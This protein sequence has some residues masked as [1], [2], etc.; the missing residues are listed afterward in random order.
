MVFGSISFADCIVKC[1]TV[2]KRTKVVPESLNPTWNAELKFVGSKCEPIINKTVVRIALYDEDRL[3][4]DDFLGEI[5]VPVGFL[6]AEDA[7]PHWRPV[8]TRPGSDDFVS[9]E[10][11]LSIV[12]QGDENAGAGDSTGGAKK[13]KT[14]AG[15]ASKAAKDAPAIDLQPQ[16]IIDPS[17]LDFTNGKTLGE[18]SFGSV[19]LGEFRGL[20]VA[21]KT[22]I[23]RAD[24][25]KAEVVSDFKLEVE[26]MSKVSH[27]PKLC[28]FL[29]ASV[30]EPL[31]VVTELMSGG[32]VRG[33]LEKA[34]SGKPEVA[35]YRRRL[36]TCLDGA[37][38]M[39]FLHRANPPVLHRDLK[40]DNLL[41]DE[42]GTAKVADFGF[43]TTMRG[44]HA[45]E[46]EILG[47]PGFMAPEMV[48][49]PPRLTPTVRLVSTSFA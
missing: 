42:H 24:A 20:G 21:V 10:V 25:N 18:G 27:H 49:R 26:I 33:L 37:L 3:S 16:Y 41:I 13:L 38:G 23:L 15:G 31:T 47:T 5:L 2:E 30:V 36:E 4:D 44:T 28:L 1:G 29:G 7:Q 8:E 12:K 48:S 34:A 6:T 14:A 9:G 45:A 46:H 19:R 22:M 17:E 35:T 40:C 43:T 39:E 11:Y 32:S